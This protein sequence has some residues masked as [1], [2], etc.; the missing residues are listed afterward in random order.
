MS[1]VQVLIIGGGGVG[2]MAAYALETGGKASVTMVLR[3]NFAAVQQNGFTIDSI[4]HGHDIKNWRP[5]HLI[6]SVPDVKDSNTPAYDYI[7]A[8]T[9]NVPDVKPTVVD[10]IEPAVTPGK[11]TILLLQNGLNIEKPFLQKFPDN[12]VLSGVSLISATE[13]SHGVIRHDD[14]DDCKVGLFPNPATQLTTT[15]AETSTRT[16]IEA[17]NA[18][19]KVTW[20]YDP[21]VSFT[22]WRKLL[23]NSSFNSVSALL[24][25]LDTP[26]MRMSEFVIDDLILPIMYEIRS[27]AKAAGVVLP[28]GIEQKIVR[29][30]PTNTGFV[31]SMGQDAAKGNFMEVEVIVG[32]PMREGR[33]LRVPVPKLEAMYGLLKA[34]QLMVMERRGLWV[35]EFGEGAKYA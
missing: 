25:G 19:G 23:Y 12:T 8:A 6:N 18:S 20:S 4:Q 30:D 34:K 33:R 32:E 14:T 11:T 35:A 26:W 24:S 5:S 27:V 13:T 3:S 29:T 10:I 21:D 7:I 28:D 17:H 15:V 1:K 9:K 31:P 22:R 16:L 2:T